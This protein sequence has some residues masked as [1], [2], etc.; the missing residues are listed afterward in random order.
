MENALKLS[1]KLKVKVK[2]G[3]S[4][5][6]LKDLDV[7]A[8]GKASW[9]GSL[10]GAIARKD[11]DLITLSPTSWKQK[12]S[13]PAG[14]RI[15]ILY[16]V[17]KCVWEFILGS[18]M[19]IF[20]LKEYLWNCLLSFTA[21]LNSF[22]TQARNMHLALWVLACLM[23]LRKMEPLPQGYFQPFQDSDNCDTDS[24]QEPRAHRIWFH[25]WHQG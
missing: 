20:T 24:Q 1:V 9:E 19:T 12:P 13:R 10:R 21:A 22:S 25:V 3:A 2:I 7:W 11:G 8:A 6:E 4:W 18:S 23:S 17:S 16:G 15:V 14:L 5:G